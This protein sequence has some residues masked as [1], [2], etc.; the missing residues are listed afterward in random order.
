MKT[1]AIFGS[2]VLHL[3]V[4]GAGILAWIVAKNN[5]D[6]PA[7]VIPVEMVEISDATNIRPQAREEP[8]PTPEPPQEEVPPAPEPEPQAEALPAPEP[9]PPEEKPEAREPAPPPPQ[10]KPRTPKPDASSDFDRILNRVLADNRPPRT[11]APAP[12]PRGPRT[13]RGIGNMDAAT[14]DIQAAMRRQMMECWNIPAGAPNAEE[15]IV[16]VKIRLTPDGNL[17]GAPEL[18]GETR[19]AM[20]SNPYMRTAAESVL[21]ALSICEPYRLPQDR[22]ALWREMDMEFNPRKPLGQ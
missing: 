11:A 9:P 1:E 22:Y 20:T 8:K 16:F 15:L 3:A 10:Q 14:M 12:A 17:A 21:R 2:F 4:L 5:I 7:Q 19:A 18:S 13:Q 6:M